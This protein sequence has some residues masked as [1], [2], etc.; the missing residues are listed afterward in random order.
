MGSGSFGC[1]YKAVNKFDQTIKIAIKCIRKKDLSSKDL[2]LLHNEIK[3]LQK[4][5]HINICSYH[6][7]YEDEHYLYICMDL[8]EGG[9]L[10]EKL[11]ERGKP[12]SER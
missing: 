3:I 11:I 6:E 12:F 4:I 8:C 7:N 9:N 10:H 1:V 2:Q 5:D